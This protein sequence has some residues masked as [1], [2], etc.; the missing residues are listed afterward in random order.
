MNKNDEIF[1][2]V[3]EEII[4]TSQE[5]IQIEKIV[6]LIRSLLTERAKQLN[7]EFNS[8]EPQGSTGIKQTQLRDDFDIDIFIGLDFNK[9]LDNFN[10]LSKTKFKKLVKRDFLNLCNE[11]IIKSLTSE[12][13][14]DPKLLYAEHPYV[15]VNYVKD[16]LKIDLDI[17]LYFDLDLKFIRKNGPIT[18]VDRTPWHGRFIRD[19]LTDVQKNQVRLL[20]QLFKACHSYGDMSAVGKVGFIGYS[21]ELLIYY[22]HDITKVMENFDKLDNL[23]N[24]ILDHF[25]RDKMKLENIKHFQNDHLLIIDPI[26][27]N[28]NVGSAISE[29]AYKFC[30]YKINEFLQNPSKEFF[31]IKEIPLF[32]PNKNRDI[33]NQFFILEFESIDEDTHYTEKRDKL[34]SL[35]EDIKIHAEKEYSHEE[36]FGNIYFEVYF[37]PKIKEFNLALFCNNPKISPTYIRRGPPL[38]KGKHVKRFKQKNSNYFEKNGYLW[39]EEKRE[40]WDFI[41]FLKQ[42]VQ[43]K[44]PES[45]QCINITNSEDVKTRSGKKALYVLQNWVLPFI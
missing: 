1:N 15:K 24:I 29:K 22:L 31:K 8:I 11:W 19:R 7:I 6:D 10:S 21:A 45:L 30:K 44:I 43:G 39:V 32:H 41:V 28:R 23:D 37:Q 27:K 12:E 26:D 34:Y 25:N 17:V 2:K 36:R 16:N 38:K 35:G 3:L 5:L 18:A 4:P 42:F 33:L 14:K 20:K 9:Y 13:F 40:F